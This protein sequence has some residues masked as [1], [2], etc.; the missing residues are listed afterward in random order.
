MS[1][2]SPLELSD[3]SPAALASCGTAILKSIGP[4]ATGSPPAPC[5]ILNKGGCFPSRAMVVLMQVIRLCPELVERA[6]NDAE[7]ELAALDHLRT[8][9]N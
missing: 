7:A 5:A 3:I 2:S 1:G 6:G 9:R 8:G 4:S